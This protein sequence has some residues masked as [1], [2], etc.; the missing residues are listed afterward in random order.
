MGIEELLQEL[1]T[2]T[3]YLDAEEARHLREGLSEEELAI[4]DILMR[5]EPVLSKAQEVQVKK[6]AGVLLSKL[7]R[8]KLMLSPCHGHMAECGLPLPLA[9]SAPAMES[10]ASI[11]IQQ[12]Q[13]AS[14]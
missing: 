8:D 11:R 1:K 3:G 10:D 14:R 4:L 2:F 13:A 12:S 6:I 7:K 5:P 9:S